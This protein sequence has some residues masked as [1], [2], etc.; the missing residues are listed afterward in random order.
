MPVGGC[1]KRNLLQSVLIWKKVTE[2]GPPGLVSTVGGYLFS[3]GGGG[4]KNK[5]KLP[6]V[7][8][9]SEKI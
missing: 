3:E 1:G 7:L 9:K 4:E 6:L 2:P 8:E 5:M